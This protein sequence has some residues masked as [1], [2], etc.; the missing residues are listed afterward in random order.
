MSDEQTRLQQFEQAALRGMSIAFHAGEEPDRLAIESMF[1]RRS[2]GE[3]NANANRLAR[4]LRAVGVGEDDGVALLCRNRPEFAE[5]YAAALRTGARITPINWHLM[6]EEV[7]YIVENCEAKVLLADS[8]F[9][10]AALAAKH[11]SSHLLEGIAIG[12]PIEGFDAYD[13]VLAP[14]DDSNIDDPVLG[15]GMLYT[16]GT[17][18][19]PKGVYR[20]PTRPP[21][22]SPLLEEVRASMAM[23]PGEDVALVTGPLYHAAPLGLNFAIPIG[24]GVGCVLQ[25]RWDAEQTLELI[26]RHQITHTHM[27]ATMFHRIL[28]L[29]EEVRGRYDLSSLRWLVHGAA[30]TPQHIKRKMIDWLGPVLWEYYAATEGGSYWIG[31]EEWL[32]KPGSVGRPI[33]GTEAILLDDD[34]ERV[35]QG[36]TGTVYFRAP[37]TGRFVYFKAPEKTAKAYRGDYYTMGDMGY[38]D[39]DGYLFL[40][41]R[42]AETIISGGVN[43]YPQ[44]ID[45]VLHQHPAVHEVCTIGVPNEEWGESVK[46]VIELKPGFEI[47]EELS[48]E[49]LQFAREHLPDYKRPRSIDFDT[50]LPRM[51]TGKIQRHKVRSRYWQGRESSI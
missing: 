19:H 35:A 34:G 45:D 46:S 26:E 37:D 14:Q 3:L 28:H 30:P 20:K 36:D 43:I 39:Q 4:A 22:P 11:G 6:P 25:D 21:T 5:A 47:S 27:V 9:D 10:Q 32:S 1:G 33:E 29:P 44:E 7:T 18:G 8:A 31:S 51:P 38:L 23:R 42:S 13:A 16:S 48:E 15:F 17:T 24:A 41:G 49:L 40:N 2:Y 12:G 50:D